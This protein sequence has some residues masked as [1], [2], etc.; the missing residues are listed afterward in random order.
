MNGAESLVHTLVNAGIEVCFTNP[1]TSEMHFVAALDR[2][3]GMRSVL[4]LQEA[5]ATGAADGYWRMAGKPASTLLHLG[6]GLA[7]G[8][9]NLHNAK[10]AGSGIVN[11]IG[12][13][14][15]SHIALDAPLTSDIEG[16]ARPVSHW[17]RTSPKAETVGQDAADAV[18]AAMK[19]PG[20]IA[21]LI[22]PSE[23]AWTAGGKAQPPSPNDAPLAFDEAVLQIAQSALDGPESLLLLGGRALT[24]ENL[25]T[26]G[27]IAARTGCVLLAEWANAR[28]ERG[29]GRVSVARVPYPIDQALDV[30]RPFKRIVLVGSRAPIGFFAYPGKPARLTRDDAEII[31]LAAAGSD[32]NGA[33]D[34]LCQGL[35]ATQTPPAQLAESQLPA[36]PTGPITAEAL[37]K[38]LARAIPSDAIIVDESVTTGRAFFPLTRG[39]APH[40]WLNN[41]GGS[42]GMGMPA[43]VG[44]AVACPNRKVM[45]LSG[46]G[47]AMYTVQALWTMA[48]EKLD[49]TTLIFANQSY[50]ILRGELSNVGAGNPGPR[51]TDMMSL[52]R[53]ALDWVAMAR[54]MGVEAEK[55]ATAEALAEALNAALSVTGPYLIEVTL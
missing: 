38:V 27:R 54:G 20:Q 53:P 51:A 12:E 35:G 15:P 25:Q 42:I 22:L 55:V 19:A 7:N 33:L 47:S 21:S 40:T 36:A 6:P 39:A 10:K 46:D 13:H 49:V 30:L 44:A 11:I 9:S 17:V 14:A 26:A 29:A 4:A 24:S 28:M 5:V 37:A 16:I 48:R 34:A 2:I 32:L 3:P 18:R 31:P 50:Q 23:T 1:G 41:C 8:L 43:A 45:C 52:D